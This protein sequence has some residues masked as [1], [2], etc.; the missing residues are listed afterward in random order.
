MLLR[1]GRENIFTDGSIPQWNRLL[2]G[3][4]ELWDTSR[5][6][7][8]DR[9]VEVILH[10]VGEIFLKFP[11]ELAIVMSSFSSLLNHWCH[12]GAQRN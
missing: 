4:G 6:T 9:G 1:S 3:A 2:L 5:E 7:V 10:Y 12:Q 11:I 8:G